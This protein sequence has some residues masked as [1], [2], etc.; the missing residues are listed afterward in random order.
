MKTQSREEEIIKL[1][2]IGWSWSAIGS[3]FGISRSRAHQIGSGYKTE[4]PYRKSILERDNYTCQWKEKCNGDNDDLIVHHIDF[5]DRNNDPKNLIT[6]CNRCHQYFHVK[7][8]LNEFGH[9]PTTKLKKCIQCG[10]L[11]L[12]SSNRK[13]CCEKCMKEYIYNKQKRIC[14][15]CGKEYK[16]IQFIRPTRF[17]S[18]ICLGKY[19]G[20]HFGFQKGRK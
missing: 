7:N 10:K 6:L 16:T 13:A 2:S 3:S 8:G 11:I 20:A 12:A 15:T 5:D 18:R 9:R 14:A 1:R 19:I 4:P 17:C